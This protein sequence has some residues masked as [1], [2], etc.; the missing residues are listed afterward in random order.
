MTRN[1]QV[2]AAVSKSLAGV[3]DPFRVMEAFSLASFPPDYYQATVELLDA[4]KTVVLSSNA[5]FY[6]SLNTSLP[7]SW[8][9]Y[10]PLPPANDPSYVNIR[11]MQY[12]R[13]GN[14]ARARP[15]LEEACRRSPDSAPFALDLC[16]VLFELKDHDAVRSLA[17]PFYRDKKNYEFAQYLGESSQALGRYGEAIGFYKDY[18]TYFGTNLIVL[19]AIGECYVQTGDLAGAITVWRKSLELSPNQAELKQKLAA[20]QDKIKED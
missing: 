11:G 6:V 1:D 2:V 3:P 14:M 12:F 17:T 20:I 19:N 13:A 10:A 18:L 8:I 16:Q 7:R 4:A 5:S 15:L 9:M